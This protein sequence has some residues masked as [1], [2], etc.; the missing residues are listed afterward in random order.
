MAIDD[1]PESAHS[2]VTLKT[3][4]PFGLVDAIKLLKSRVGDCV[5]SALCPSPELVRHV[6]K[7]QRR[8]KRAKQTCQSI[9][10]ENVPFHPI[11]FFGNVSAAKIITIGLNPSSGE[12][13]PWRCWPEK[14]D[15]QELA[16]RLVGY[17]RHAHPR[18]HPWFAELQEALSIVNCSYTLAAAHVDASPWPAFSPS[19]LK[20][21]I[22]KRELPACYHEMILTEKKHLRFFLKKCKNLKLIFII[23]KENFGDF[24]NNWTKLTKESVG[25]GF[26]GI[27]EVVEKHKL[28]K[29]ISDHEGEIRK[30]TDLPPNIY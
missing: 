4:K 21:R 16:L 30:L 14:L 19:S 25:Q 6:A 15:E 7:I 23:G 26:Q 1:I 3:H 24:D 20:K 29:W 5:D 28:S 22:N 9:L 12:F 17:F 8:A 27:V 18:P 13:E 2:V 10:R 11:P